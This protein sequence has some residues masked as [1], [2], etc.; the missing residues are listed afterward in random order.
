M[1][2]WRKGKEKDKQEVKKAVKDGNKCLVKGQISKRKKRKVKVAKKM[3]KKE[4]KMQNKKK[5][6]KYI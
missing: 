3:Q 5:K 2:E 1:G 4:Y 6:E